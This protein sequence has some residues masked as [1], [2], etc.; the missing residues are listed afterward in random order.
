MKSSGHWPT[1]FLILLSAL[2]EPLLTAPSQ[3]GRFTAALVLAPR[4]DIRTVP[5]L[6][7]MMRA[8]APVSGADEYLRHFEGTP[9][10]RPDWLESYI[11]GDDTAA[12]EAARL[13]IASP[14]RAYAT[15]LVQRV[16]AGSGKGLLK[17][18]VKMARVD[19]PPLAAK[20]HAQLARAARAWLLLLQK[21]DDA[22]VRSAAVYAGAEQGDSSTLPVTLPLAR[23]TGKCDGLLDQYDCNPYENDAVETLNLLRRHIHPP[24]TFPPDVCNIG[25]LPAPVLASL[26]QLIAVSGDSAAFSGLLQAL[27]LDQ[28]AHQEALR[29]V[30]EQ[31][32]APTL[33]SFMSAMPAVADVQRA[34]SMLSAIAV[35]LAWREGLN[36]CA[37]AA[38]QGRQDLVA[39]IHESPAAAIDAKRPGLSL[40]L[41]QDQ[42]QTTVP[43]LERLTTAV[44]DAARL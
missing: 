10:L 7:E 37:I 42:T 11:M 22:H 12:E 5:I 21:D 25:G 35:G 41:L 2:F 20:A 32:D 13:A 33:R 16:P 36:L 28:D 44:G 30:G 6:L 39:A 40:L 29:T 1:I 4:R 27:R 31:L 8:P 38:S 26:I 15:A 3:A 18:M 17:A 23:T 24:Q 43:A 9:G 19:E 14:D 34:G